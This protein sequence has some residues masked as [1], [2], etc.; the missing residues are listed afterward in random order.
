LAYSQ[1]SLH[2]IN[3]LIALNVLTQK[4]SEYRLDAGL[5]ISELPV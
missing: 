2:V 5:V 1:S 4:Q 3:Y